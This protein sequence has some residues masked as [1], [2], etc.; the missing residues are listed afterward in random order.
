MSHNSYIKAGIMF[1][2]GQTVPEDPEPLEKIHLN[3]LILPFIILGVGCSV[4]LV[5]FVLEIIWKRKGHQARKANT[6][7][8]QNM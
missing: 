8:N 7:E 5:V 4:A 6:G 2:G 3:H 1:Y